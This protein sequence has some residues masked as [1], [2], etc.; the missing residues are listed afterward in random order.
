MKHNA[1]K[2][3][4]I[5]SERNVHY[6]RRFIINFC[7]GFRVIRV[8]SSLEIVPVRWSLSFFHLEES[9]RIVLRNI[10][11]ENANCIQNYNYYLPNLYLNFI[12]ISYNWLARFI[13]FNSFTSNS[14][15]NRIFILIAC[16]C[17][18]LLLAPSSDTNIS[19]SQQNFFLP[20]FSFYTGRTR[21]ASSIKTKPPPP[22]SP[23]AGESSKNFFFSPPS[24][25]RARLNRR[26][27]ICE[28]GEFVRKSYNRLNG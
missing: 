5:F 13:G 16:S 18:F 27:E 9:R 22:S 23:R 17:S 3:H 24:P 20:P 8:E 26:K 14:N 28:R 15:A 25:S 2:W 19:I 10:L 4:G 6:R 7:N 11:L 12:K 1:S 21:F